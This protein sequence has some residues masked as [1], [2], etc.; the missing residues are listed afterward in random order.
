MKATLLSAALVAL[1][2]PA[3]AAGTVDT[4][5]WNQGG[6]EQDEALHLTPNYENGI[7]VYEVC[8]AC[9]QLNGWGLDDGT[10]PQISGQHYTVIIK[11]LADIRA[12]NRDNPTMYPFALPSEIGG[13]Q[14]IADVAEYISKLPMNPNNGVGKGDDLE[15]GAQ[16]YKDNCV[17]CHGENGEGDN[18]KF[19]PRIHGQHY[20]YL[21]RQYQ[22]IKEGKRRNANPDMVQQI[23]TF[24]ERD[25]LAVLDYVSRLKPP[26]E[27]VGD[28][29][30]V[31]PDFDW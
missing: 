23:Q 31:N 25:T 26:A 5:S 14:A 4:S 20:N 18:D 3:L 17:R 15:L 11:Q 16:L 7:E 6:G 24:T 19:Y 27:L 9:H 28:P 22:W 29:D 13:S 12:L 8:S 30:W 10:F 1:A 21:V 2:L